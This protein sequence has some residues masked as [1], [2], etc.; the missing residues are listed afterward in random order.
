MISTLTCPRCNSR[1]IKR[2]RYASWE[3]PLGAKMVAQWKCL[4]CG[5]SSNDPAH[6]GDA[7]P[8]L[9]MTMGFAILATLVTALVCLL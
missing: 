8:V 9:D 3:G 6:G 4:G 2:I 5:E 1:K 7:S